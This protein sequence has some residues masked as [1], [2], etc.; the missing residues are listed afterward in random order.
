MLQATLALAI[1]RGLRLLLRL[2]LTLLP[3]LWHR[4]QLPTT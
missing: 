4:Q 3:K 1:F 2:P